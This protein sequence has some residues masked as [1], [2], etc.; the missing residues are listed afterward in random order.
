MLGA[1][2]GI[3]FPKVCIGCNRA[4]VKNEEFLCSYCTYHLPVTDLHLTENN[5]LEKTFWGRTGIERAYA[6]LYFKRGNVTRHLLH[7]LKYK[8]NKELG[9]FLG[10]LYGH[11][12]EDHVGTIDAVVA[13]PL[14]KSKLR[15]RGYN[16]SASFAEGLASRLNIENRSSCVSR[17]VA[18][19]TQTKRSRYERWENVEEIFEVTDR[20]MLRNKHIL[21]VDDVITTGATIESCA[22]L[23]KTTC[24]CKISVASIALTTH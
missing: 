13:V 5:M 15:K 23:L 6:F 24:D 16:Q 12:L 14:H 9:I 22:H 4:L 18:T 19:G 3:L 2:L 11:Q 10:Q 7:E 1:L 21:L 8:G 17:K 20:N